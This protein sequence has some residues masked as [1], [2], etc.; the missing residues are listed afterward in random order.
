MVYSKSAGTEKG[1]EF[2]V[3]LMAPM[4]MGIILRYEGVINHVVKSKQL[5]PILEL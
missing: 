2:D 3:K 5:E 1:W 4:E